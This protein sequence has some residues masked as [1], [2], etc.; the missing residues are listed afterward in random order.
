MISSPNLNGDVGIICG[1]TKKEE[2]EKRLDGKSK[3]RIA[4]IGQLYSKEGLNYIIRNIFLNPGLKYLIV[5]GSNLSGSIDFMKDFLFGTS[6]E[7]GIFHKEIPGDK[8]NQFREWFKDHT[9]FVEEAD[10]NDIISKLKEH[11][12]N[13][14]EKPEEFPEAKCRESIDLPSE[15]VGIRLEK[16]KVAELW[17]DV[18]YH[19][20]KFGSLKKTQY[21]GTQKEL[22]G[23]TTVISNEDPCNLYLPNYLTFGKE[24]LD[25]YL[26]QMMTAENFTGIEYTYGEQLRNHGGINQ[27]ESIIEQIMSEN[28]TRRAIATTWDVKKHNKNPKSPCLISIQALVNGGYLQLICY[29]RSNDMYGAWPQNALALRSIQKEIADSTGCK[30]GKLIIISASAHIYEKDFVK[31]LEVVKRNRPKIGCV[32]DERGDFL[33][34]VSDSKIKATHLL[35]AGGHPIQSFEGK[36]ARELMIKIT[37][38]ISQIPHALYIGGELLKAEIALENGTEYIQD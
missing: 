6:Y 26:P 33:I 35:P 20:M 7:D 23:L 31:A 10:I 12:E 2:I 37:P 3:K 29:I 4:A 22:V 11:E 36:S 5:A 17:L 1:W 24:E 15:G 28:F 9:L 21:G 8:I 25:N 16:R 14:I 32:E 13:W 27:I 38:F 34:S 19:I 30:M 18:L